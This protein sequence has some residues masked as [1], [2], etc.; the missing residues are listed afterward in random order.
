MTRF[1]RCLIHAG[2]PKTGSTTLQAFFAANRRALRARGILYPACLGG[3]SHV[4]LAAALHPGP[5]PQRDSALR[6]LGLSDPA[7]L[8]PLLEARL[9]EEIEAAEPCGTLLLSSEFF[10]SLPRHASMLKRL[11]AFAARHAARSEVVVWLRR[12]DEFAVSIAATRAREGR[13][14][15]GQPVFPEQPRGAYRINATLERFAEAFGEAALRPRIF[16]RTCMKD[17]DLVADA[18]E[19]LGIPAE[20]PPLAIPPRRNAALSAESQLWLQHLAALSPDRFGQGPGARVE[21]GE[22]VERRPGAPPRPAAAAAARFMARFEAQNEL[23]R[24]RWFPGRETLFPPP[25]AWPE[26]ADPPPGPEALM[27]LTRDALLLKEAEIARLRARLALTREDVHAARAEFA[28]AA[29]LTPGHPAGAAEWAAVLLRAPR[30]AGKAALL[31]AAEETALGLEKAQAA[32]MRARLR[33]LR[34]R[35]LFSAG[36]R[37][38]ARREAELLAQEHPERE[39]GA[40]LLR[41]MTGPKGDA[42]GSEGAPARPAAPAEAGAAKAR[43]GRNR[44]AA[45]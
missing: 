45:G 13:S 34:A 14:P 25:P 3:R 22:V 39:E 4:H 24:A 19:A 36:E 7:A 44:A 9:A 6:A 8:A 27:A 23:A 43:G 38:A 26:A 30:A 21:L 2:M 35:L 12:Q 5:S 32:S 40:R 31:A 33:G 16:A 11:A 29:A 10:W 42:P 41:R 15:P 28:R 17:G 37:E 1:A 20:G 18:V